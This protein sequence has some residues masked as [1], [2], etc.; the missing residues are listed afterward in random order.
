MARDQGHL[1]VCVYI[2]VCVCVHIV[3]CACVCMCMCACM[4]ACLSL[5]VDRRRD[6]NG[7]HIRLKMIINGKGPCMFAFGMAFLPFASVH[8]VISGLIY[9]ASAPC[10]CRCVHA[11]LQR[12]WLKLTEI[13]RNLPKLTE[14]Y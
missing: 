14:T 6:S 7:A 4:H 2:V 5:S 3:V 13:Y 1:K 12:M 11:C 10:E 8:K 9:N